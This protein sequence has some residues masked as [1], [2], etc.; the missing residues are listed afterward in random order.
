MNLPIELAKQKGFKIESTH[1]H[2]LV[3]TI[4]VEKSNYLWLCLLQDYILTEFKIWVY[5]NC[6]DDLN[7]WNYFIDAETPSAFERM[8]I[9]TG[10]ESRKQALCE[11]CK[12]G[13]ELIP[14]I[15]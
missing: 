15:N 8:E 13:L 1:W 9:G 4:G 3:R 2:L 14:D 10:F 12:A 5:V 7:E 6:T 11:G